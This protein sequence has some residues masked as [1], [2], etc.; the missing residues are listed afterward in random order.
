MWLVS[1]RARTETQAF[2]LLTFSWHG[3]AW[4]YGYNPIVTMRCWL[5]SESVATEQLTEKRKQINIYWASSV[6]SSLLNT[7]HTFTWWSQQPGEA[8]LIH[9]T[10]NETEVRSL[11]K[12]N[13]P[14]TR[15][16]EL[17]TPASL[18]L[19]S[20]S[21][22]PGGRLW[23]SSLIHGHGKFCVSCSLLDIYYLGDLGQVT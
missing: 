11:I 2:W 21:H 22:Y 7:L 5:F 3:C 13:V 1:N 20:T 9:C 19:L 18:T 10:G 23:A 15:G 14:A 4:F 16:R 6:S 8:R 17:K 12:V